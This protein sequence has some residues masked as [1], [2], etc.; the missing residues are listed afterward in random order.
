MLNGQI[1]TICNLLFLS[2]VHRRMQVGRYLRR[3]LVQPPVQSRVMGS[4]QVMQ[5]FI[6]SLSRLQFTNSYMNN[7]QQVVIVVVY[8]VSQVLPFFFPN[9]SFLR[10]QG[11]CKKQHIVNSLSLELIQIIFFNLVSKMEKYFHT[12]ILSS[13]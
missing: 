8:R 4:N 11:C 3:S 7:L 6:P 5:G 12:S 1:K 10:A 9:E 2:L 13:K